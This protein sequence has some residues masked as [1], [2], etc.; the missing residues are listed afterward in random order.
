MNNSLDKKP[1]KPIIIIKN[2]LEIV[3]YPLPENFS[4]RVVLYF[5]KGNLQNLSK[6]QFIDK[7]TII[8]GRKP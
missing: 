6:Q 7:K 1:I 4:G 8:Q 3:E 2:D 5:Q